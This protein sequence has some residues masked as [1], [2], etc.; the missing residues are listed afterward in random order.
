[1]EEGIVFASDSRSNAGIDNITSVRKLRVYEVPDDRVIVILSAGNLAT[2]QA[3]TALLGTGQGSG[4]VG[5]DVTLAVNMFDA[6]QL[7]GDR[8]RAQIQRDGKYVEAF[9]DPNATFIVGGQVKGE[10]PRLFEV[11][12][13][14]NFVEI[15]QRRPFGQIGEAKYG[16]PIL[17]RA[18]GFDTSLDEATKLALLSFDATIRSNLSVAPPV[19]VLRYRADSF[20]APEVECFTMQGAYWKGLQ[21]DFNEGVRTLVRS[22]RPPNPGEL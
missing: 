15:T 21:H 17:D 9:G 8:L 11:Y 16:K 18:F 20:T 14:G 13:A 7:V 6:A 19:D 5:Q 4:I 22:L 10:R 2:T 3:V 12:S 1:M